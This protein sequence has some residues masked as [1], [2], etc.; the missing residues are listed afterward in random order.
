MYSLFFSIPKL[1]KL[2][3]Y[4]SVLYSFNPL[5]SFFQCFPKGSVKIKGYVRIIGVNSK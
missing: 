5:L 3:T 2:L 4:S 1:S